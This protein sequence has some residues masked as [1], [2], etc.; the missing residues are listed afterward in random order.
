MKPIKHLLSGSR[1]HELSRVE[2]EVLRAGL[3][4][5]KSLHRGLRLIAL[6]PAK[7]RIKPGMKRSLA[8]PMRQRIKASQQEFRLVAA[9]EVFMGIEVCRNSSGLNSE[10]RKHRAPRG[11]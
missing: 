10:T 8:H 4:V 11:F 1:C 3:G 9:L 5:L 7:S 2:E 6:K